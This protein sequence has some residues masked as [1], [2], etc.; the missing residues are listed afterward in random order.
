MTYI[1]N[2]RAPLLWESDGEYTGKFLADDG[3]LHDEA[4]DVLKYERE[5]DAAK[6]R[7]AAPTDSRRDG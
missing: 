2:P 4:N 6:K 7:L 3:T 5:R 1:R